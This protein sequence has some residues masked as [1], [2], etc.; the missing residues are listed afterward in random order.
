M[1]SSTV[2]TA[3]SSVLLSL[4]IGASAQVPDFLKSAAKATEPAKSPPQPSPANGAAQLRK[5]Q[6]C[7]GILLRLLLRSRP[8]PKQ[9]S[10]PR[11][12]PLRP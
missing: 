5:R 7:H 10:L 6:S 9:Y 11:N 4:S 2:K 1:A 3:V 8:I 12:R